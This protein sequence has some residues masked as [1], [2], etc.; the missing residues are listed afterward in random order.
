MAEYAAAKV[1]HAQR[2]SDREWSARFLAGDKSAAREMKLLEIII[3]NG[4]EGGAP[5]RF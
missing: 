4:P 2:M 3:T 1:L 5:V